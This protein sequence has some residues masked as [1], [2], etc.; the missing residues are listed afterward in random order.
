MPH[1][2]VHPAVL[3][4][5][6]MHTPLCRH[7]VGAPY[8]YATAAW[9]QRLGGIIMTCHNPMPPAYTHRGRM[10]VEELPQYIA[11]VGEARAKWAG[12][13]D[14]LLGLEC[15]YLPGLDGMDDWLRETLSSAEFH[16]ILGSIH[17]HIADYREAFY[18]GDAFAFQKLYFEHL[19]VAAETGLFDCLAHPDLVKNI[20]ASDWDVSRLLDYIRRSLDRIARTGVA[21]ELNTSGLTKTVSETNPGPLI[22]AEM[23]ARGIPVVLGSDAHKPERV[24]ESFPE[25]LRMLQEIGYTAISLFQHRK[26]SEIP[27]Q[28]ALASLAE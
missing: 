16:Y 13:V 21:M 8:E 18:R 1:S 12:K 7:A 24:G 2:N 23:H 14:V 4:D 10:R 26:R 5:S 19:A 9:R 28:A 3:Y 15:D 20:T 27:L 11:M 25:A 6:H 17:P 22:L